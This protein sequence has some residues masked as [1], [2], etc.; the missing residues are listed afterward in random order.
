VSRLEGLRVEGS[1]DGR[2]VAS[3]ERELCEGLTTTGLRTLL[4]TSGLI[5]CGGTTITRLVELD[6]AGLPGTTRT[7]LVSVCPIVDRS[8]PRVD[9]LIRMP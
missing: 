7:P 6:R 8:P 9:G 4:R 1:V 5:D 2:E 3:T